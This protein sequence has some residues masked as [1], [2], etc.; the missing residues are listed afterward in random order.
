M[1]RATI[2][3]DLNR[4]QFS[5]FQKRGAWFKF[6]RWLIF[7]YGFQATVIYR[8]GYW[9]YCKEDSLLRKLFKIG[10]LM[11]YGVLVFLVRRMYGITL[12]RKAKIGPGL[13]VGH[14]GNIKIGACLMGENC[15]IQQSVHI[16]E[17]DQNDKI[18]KIGSRVWIGGHVRIEPGVIIGDRATISVGSLVSRDV[19][20]KSL[21]AGKS[22]RVINKNYDNSEILGL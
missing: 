1:L 18:V 4:Y 17:N 22:G 8:L 15:S 21:V 14:F 13:Y 3:K 7:A 2:Q 12:S 6:L 10:P 16:G 20:A 5:L 9:S 19:P 11:L